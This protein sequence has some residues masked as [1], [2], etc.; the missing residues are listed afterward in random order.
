MKTYERV[1]LLGVMLLFC[2]AFSKSY[3]TIYITYPGKY[4]PRDGSLPML[5]NLNMNNFSIIW[6]GQLFG[7]DMKIGWANLTAYPQSC[8]EGY[9]VQ[10]VGDVLTC[11]PLK[12][13]GQVNGT[14]TP[15]YIPKFITN[16]SIGDSIMYENNSAI[17]VNGSLYIGGKEAA[18]KEWIVQRY[19]NKTE[20]DAIE[21]SQ[22]A[23][24]KAWATNAFVNKCSKHLQYTACNC[25]LFFVYNLFTIALVNKL[26]TN[27]CK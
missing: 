16:T 12:V 10:G 9:A 14:G 13:A 5:G 22:N 3:G 25:L 4:L 23:S 2:H 8:P 6:V 21:E 19:Y 20:I 24:L 15:G 1:L 7:M 27:K 11:V 26:L 18:T 17:Y